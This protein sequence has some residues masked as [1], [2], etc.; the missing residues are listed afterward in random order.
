MQLYNILNLKFPLLNFTSDI[1]LHDDG[2]GPFIAQWNVPNVPEPTQE[3]LAQWAVELDLQYR[4]QQAR[5][6]RVYP[7][8]QEQADMQYWDSVNGTTVWADTVAA[9]KEAS[10]IPNE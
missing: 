2:N 7:S 5:N 9:I 4:Q 3:D 10:P 8:W 1:I 6:A